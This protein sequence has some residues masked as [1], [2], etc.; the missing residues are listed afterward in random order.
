M[1]K[2]KNIAIYSRNGLADHLLKFA[3]VYVYFDCVDVVI[4]GFACVVMIYVCVIYMDVFLL[5]S[6]VTSLFVLISLTSRSSLVI[7]AKIL[8]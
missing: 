2:T 7:L 6:F 1:E 3:V 8:P 4:F 5:P